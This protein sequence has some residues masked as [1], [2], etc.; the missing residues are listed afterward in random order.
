MAKK[1]KIIPAE[2]G[3]RVV[4]A[5]LDLSP[6]ER[7]DAL[8]VCQIPLVGWWLKTDLVDGTPYLEPVVYAAEF[9]AS[10]TD[11][12]SGERIDAEP[13]SEL[14]GGTTGHVGYVLA[15]WQDDP[16]NIR[17][18]VDAEVARKAYDREMDERVN[19]ARLIAAERARK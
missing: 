2:P 9:Y 7:T 19:R 4:I 5:S 15:E 16:D 11:G 14:I 17:M 10:S 13:I 12:Y 8:R 3:W 18:R 1:F 6:G